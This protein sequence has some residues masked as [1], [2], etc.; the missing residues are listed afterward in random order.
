LDWALLSRAALDHQYFRSYPCYSTIPELLGIRPYSE[1]GLPNFRLPDSVGF[2]LIGLCS[3]PGTIF[4]VYQGPSGFGTWGLT[5]LGKGQPEGNFLVPFTWDFLPL[6][7]RRPVPN[8]GAFL[9]KEWSLNSQAK[10]ELRWSGKGASRTLGPQFQDYGDN[11]QGTHL[12]PSYFL[13]FTLPG[14]PTNLTN[15]AI[16]PFMALLGQFLA[17]RENR[18]PWLAL[19][20]I[21]PGF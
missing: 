5:A 10:G 14:P 8:L 9:A 7:G 13:I 11:P 4:P 21:S 12:D 17:Q 2:L 18:L 20:T 16:H 6:P 1:I 3:N 19:P 15:P